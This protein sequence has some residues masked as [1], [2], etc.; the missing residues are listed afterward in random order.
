MTLLQLTP[1]QKDQLHML[2]KRLLGVKY[3]FGA[4]VNM[5]DTIDEIKE[6]DC[7]EMTQWLFY[8]LGLIIRDGSFNQYSDSKT[9]KDVEV[10]DLVFKIK[11]GA[12]NHVGVIMAVSPTIVCEA[13]GYRG[14]VVLTP[15][16]KF[17][18]P[19]PRA[20]QYA[21]LRRLVKEKVK[22]V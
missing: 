10:G 9:V 12:I 15:F 2:C 17:S 21:G 1:Q 20:S 13:D 5:T 11:N 4:E 19:S 7:S 6:L 22:V 16:D 14:K 8:Q 18:T 3:K